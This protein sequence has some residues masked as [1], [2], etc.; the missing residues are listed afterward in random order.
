MKKRYAKNSSFFPNINTANS[1]N[2]QQKSCQQKIESTL[3]LWSNTMFCISMFRTMDNH[4]RTERL[5]QSL[6][7][8]IVFLI[9]LPI[10]NGILLKTFGYVY[11]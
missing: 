11:K 8:K 3:G 9:Q 1:R 10:F 6:G 4:R 7:I 2:S 5:G